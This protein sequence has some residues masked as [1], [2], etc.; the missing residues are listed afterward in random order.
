MYIDNSLD[1]GEIETDRIKLKA[2]RDSLDEDV[3]RLAAET[4]CPRQTEETEQPREQ[5]VGKAP[6]RD[7]RDVG[8]TG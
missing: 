6:P 7:D 1:R 4:P 8:E 3:N 2:R 5:R